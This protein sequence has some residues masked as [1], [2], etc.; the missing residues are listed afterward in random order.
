MGWSP[1]C[2]IVSSA[3]AAPPRSR[4]IEPRSTATVLARIVIVT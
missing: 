2:R 3:L 4:L 1:G